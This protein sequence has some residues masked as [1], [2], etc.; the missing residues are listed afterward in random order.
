MR[1]RVFSR[2]YHG[3]TFAEADGIR[4]RLIKPRTEVSF[5]IQYYDSTDRP[6]LLFGTLLEKA[7]KM[8]R[9]PNKK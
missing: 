2:S 8:K 4:A 3:I 9:N 7:S 1:K 5:K 6:N